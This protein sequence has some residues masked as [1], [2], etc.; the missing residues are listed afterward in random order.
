MGDEG[1]APDCCEVVPVLYRGEFSKDAL[2][3]VMQNLEVNGSYAQSGF[4]KP[5]GVIIWLYG[6]RM[7][8]KSTFDH[9]EGKWT[10]G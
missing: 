5:E 10:A 1:A 2:K 4:M 6:S 3:L 9:P 7:F 8:L